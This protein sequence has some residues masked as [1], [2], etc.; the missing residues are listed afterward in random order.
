M[1]SVDREDP[2]KLDYRGGQGGR[3]KGP[4]FL[5]GFLKDGSCKQIVLSWSM[6]SVDRYTLPKLDYHDG[7][8]GLREV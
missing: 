6:K 1:K 5:R 4:K 8:E 7:Q 2:P 3:T